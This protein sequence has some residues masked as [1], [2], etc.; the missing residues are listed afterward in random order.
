[1]SVIYEKNDII[2]KY[3]LKLS[4]YETAPECKYVNAKSD[5]NET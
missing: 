5:T 1:M 3:N 2:T 4:K